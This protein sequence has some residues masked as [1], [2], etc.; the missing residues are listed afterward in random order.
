MTVEELQKK[1]QAAAAAILN[2]KAWQD[3]ANLLTYEN[4]GLLAEV[5]ELHP[6]VDDAERK[7]FWKVQQEVYAR[8]YFLSRM[9]DLAQAHKDAVAEEVRN[10]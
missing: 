3:V 2:T 10:G 1:A 5:T 6:F 9:D 4:A 8:A 7:A